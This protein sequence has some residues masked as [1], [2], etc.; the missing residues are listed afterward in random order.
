LAAIHHQNSSAGHNPSLLTILLNIIFIFTLSLLSHETPSQNISIASSDK[1]EKNRRL[2]SSHCYNNHQTKSPVQKT[3]PPGGFDG[4]R[5]CRQCEWGVGGGGRGEHQQITTDF[6]TSVCRSDS[7]MEDHFVK[8]TKYLHEINAGHKLKWKN[9]TKF[10]LVEEEQ[11]WPHQEPVKEVPPSMCLHRNTSDTSQYINTV[12][13]RLDNPENEFLDVYAAAISRELTF[14]MSI[15]DYLSF[16]GKR[17][18]PLCCLITRI[19][20]L[21]LSNFHSLLLEELEILRESRSHLFL[22]APE[23]IRPRD[24]LVLDNCLDASA[25]SYKNE[26]KIT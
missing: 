2:T 15:P 21:K 17:N 24:K 6:S 12:G 20:Y 14:E 13:L 19:I 8:D 10:S 9:I 1:K 16:T 11:K 3:A 5:G 25:S 23:T 4:G 18:F 7:Q 26:L 22:S